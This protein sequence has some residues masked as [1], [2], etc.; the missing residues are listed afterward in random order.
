MKTS[1]ELTS[2]RGAH[3]PDV[4]DEVGVG[5]NHSFGVA[6][7]AR[8]VLQ[9]G[10]IFWTHRGADKSSG[11]GGYLRHGDHVAQGFDVGSEELRR[12]FGLIQSNEGDRPAVGEDAG[13]TA[14]VFLK[15]RWSGW[16]V[17]GDRNAARQKNAEEAE[18]IIFSGRQH[19]G[20]G[21]GRLKTEVLES[22]SDGGCLVT[23]G[24][25][26]DDVTL[27]LIT[28]ETDMGVIGVDG[29]VAVEHLHQTVGFGGNTLRG[30]PGRM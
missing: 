16:G 7:A 30:R 18:K 22:R 6:G 20:D 29:G 3:G 12:P 10:R 9:E 23:Q 1:V 17:D 15:A 11:W 26:G 19:D 13:M 25:V 5:Q 4:G 21:F 24:L 2:M 14:Q 27:A 28:E 8:G